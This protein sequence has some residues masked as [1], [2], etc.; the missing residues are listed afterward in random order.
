MSVKRCKVVEEFWLWTDNC[1]V[2]FFFLDGKNFVKEG[3][4][5]KR[6]NKSGNKNGN[7]NFFFIRKRGL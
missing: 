5:C 1:M 3:R 7:R 2:F 4:N 6:G